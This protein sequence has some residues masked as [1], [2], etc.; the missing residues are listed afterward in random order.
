MNAMLF[1]CSSDRLQFLVWV[2]EDGLEYG[3][4]CLDQGTEVGRVPA[5]F[6]ANRMEDRHWL[7]FNEAQ[8]GYCLGESDATYCVDAALRDTR[9]ALFVRARVKAGDPLPHM[10]VAH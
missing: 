9:A 2:G 8:S 7:V 3:D 6:I 4:V 1:G 10:K 5:I